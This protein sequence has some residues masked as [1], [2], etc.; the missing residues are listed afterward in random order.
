MRLAV[1]LSVLSSIALG[2][3]LATSA[4]AFTHV[5][6]SGETLASIAEHVYGRIQHE[7]ILVA[8]NELDVQGG[9][10]IIPGMRLEVPSL[11][12]VRIRKGDTWATLAAEHLGSP[13][14]SDASSRS[15]CAAR[16]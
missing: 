16:F 5:V 15:R 14:R 1:A 12:Y 6:Q 13:K 11:A 2:A 9:L 3:T 10:S 4:S 8:A 7:R